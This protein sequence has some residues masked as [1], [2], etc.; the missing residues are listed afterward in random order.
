M[1]VSLPRF[2]LV[3]EA[4]KRARVSEWSIRKEIRL[5]NL[6]ARRLGRCVRILDEDFAAWSRGE[7]S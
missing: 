5:G 4:A 1:T 3:P 7:Q 2:L 6:K